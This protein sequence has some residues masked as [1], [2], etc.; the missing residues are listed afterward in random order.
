VLFNTCSV[1][2]HAEERVYSW[3]GELKREKE[4][5]PELLIGVMGCMA[6]RLGGD[7]FRRSAHVDLVV[8][9]RSFQ[10]LPELVDEL[11]RR[12]ADGATARA[13]RVLATG[14][15]EAPDSPR[16][17]ETYTGGLQGWLAVMRGCDLNC[18]FCIVPTVRGRVLARPVGALVDEAR[19]MVDH[20]ARVVTLLGQTVN[21]Y[22]EDLPAPGPG[23]AHGSGRKGRPALADLLRALQE[24]DGLE[25]VRLITLH[26]A[27]VTRELALAIRD[28]PKVDRFLP[29]PAQSGSDRVLKAM[30]RGYTV[31]LYRRR[32]ELL[33][34][35]VPDIE[36]GSDWIVG[37]PGEGEEDYLATERLLEELGTV[38]NYVFKYD[39]RPGTRAAELED[40]VPLA[41]K[42]DRNR[43]LLEV[44]ERVALGRMRAFIGRGVQ[45]FVEECSDRDGAASLRGRTVHGLPVRFE[46]PAALVG[47]TVTVTPRDASAYGLAGELD[48]R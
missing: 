37:F 33:R 1:R 22:G 30:K 36:L 11:R 3:V 13:S 4:R 8:G 38:V 32:L 9:T 43:R 46:G 17:G 28:C 45:T 39:P 7:V 47:S 44:G 29:L 25:R 6:E 14:F 31:D 5:R 26:P 34:E 48:A 23:G 21:S 12:R 2:D 20:G 16:D 24:L 41:A 27:Y 15:E 40:D 10:A 42:K 35:H 18:T 19:W